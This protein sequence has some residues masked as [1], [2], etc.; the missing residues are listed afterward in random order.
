MRVN[1]RNNIFRRKDGPTDRINRNGVLQY[2][3]SPGS[4]GRTANCWTWPPMRNRVAIYTVRGACSKFQDCE[5]FSQCYNTRK[6]CYS[7]D[8]R[9]MRAI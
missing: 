5:Y 4:A 3:L 9:A 8:D 1:A 7:K 6:L 2:G